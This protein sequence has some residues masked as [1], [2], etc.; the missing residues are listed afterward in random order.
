MPLLPYGVPPLPPQAGN[1]GKYL[2]TNGSLPSW[3][4]VAAS[5]KQTYKYIVAAS[6]GDFTTLAAAIAAA[7]AGDTIFVRAGTY[8]E[9]DPGDALNNLTIIGENPETTILNYTTASFSFSGTKRTIQNLS[10]SFSTGRINVNGADA[11]FLGCHLTISGNNYLVTTGSLNMTIRGCR[12]LDTNTSTHTN[13]TVDFSANGGIFTD[14]YCSCGIRTADSATGWLNLAGAGC[15]VSGNTFFINSLAS[16]SVIL[17]LS[18]GAVRS[19]VTGNVFN[20]TNVGTTLKFAIFSAG[21]FSTFAGNACGEGINFIQIGNGSGS[22]TVVSGN[23]V[24]MTGSSGIGVDVQAPNCS[25]T[26]NVIKVAG[27]GVNVTTQDGTTIVGNNITGAANGVILGSGAT[28]TTVMGNSL[29]G[30][31]TPMTDTGINSYTQGNVGA[32]IVFERQMVF[33][34]NTSGA[35]INA[36]NIVTFKTGVANGNEV[37]TTVTASDNYAFGMASAAIANNASGYIQILGKTQLLTVDGTIDIGIGDY[38]TTFTTAGIGRKAAAGTLG[39]TPGD[40]AIAIALEAYTNND[41]SGV[42][43]ALIISPR[44]L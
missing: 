43:D 30:L 28:N 26:G 19:T 23:V 4:T 7:A 2:T 29:K 1:S 14:N 44:R 12:I 10:M 34:K 3:G 42:I 37:T 32:S 25:V 18:S 39:T 31:G 40:L 11:S 24:S 35:T 27:T 8:T 15:V 9:T 33:M 41:S 22:G 36:G 38:I 21:S 6:G 13:P 20:P 16:N 17:S 5:A